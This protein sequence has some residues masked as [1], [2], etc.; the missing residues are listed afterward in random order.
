MN[1]EIVIDGV[2]YVKKERQ[3]PIN[4][5]KDFEFLD[6][7]GNWRAVTENE[8]DYFQD[9]KQLNYDWDLEYDYFISSTP[10]FKYDVITRKKK[11]FV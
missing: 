1:D 5:H 6:G 4:K 2:I 10:E 3:E 9:H 11:R 7:H 8:E